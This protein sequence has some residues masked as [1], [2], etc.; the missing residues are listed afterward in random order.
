MQ[1]VRTSPRSTSGRGK[2]KRSS[3]RRQSTHRPRQKSLKY[4]NRGVSGTK[5]LELVRN[6]FAA[7]KRHGRTHKHAQ[8]RP[9]AGGTILD[10]NSSSSS[11]QR[12]S[13]PVDSRDSHPTPACPQIGNDKLNR[14]PPTRS[15]AQKHNRYD[16]CK[17][18]QASDSLPSPVRRP[19]P[20]PTRTS[21]E[22]PILHPGKTTPAWPLRTVGVRGRCRTV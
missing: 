22:P 12:G 11:S 1:Y 18:K 21:P 19:C 20:P 9:S 16:R 4:S 3:N 8:R 2:K 5:Q 6:R 7:A 15:E 14:P 10:S 13:S 17:R